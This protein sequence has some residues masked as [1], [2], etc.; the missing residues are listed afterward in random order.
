[1]ANPSTS[2]EILEWF[3]A[4]KVL[5]SA[6]IKD[7]F[8]FLYVLR[9]KQI[10]SEEEFKNWKDKVHSNPNDIRKVVYEVLENI[11]TNVSAVMEV[12]S[13][14]NLKNYQDLQSL[15]SS[16]QNV[17]QSAGNSSATEPGSSNLLQTNKDNSESSIRKQGKGIQNK[18]R[19]K[20]LG[21]LIVLCGKLKGVLYKRKLAAGVTQKCI[22]GLNGVWYTPREFEIAGGCVNAK[23]WRRSIR[24]RGVTLETLIKRGDLPEPARKSLKKVKPENDDTCEVCMEAG[25][26]MLCHS[27]CRSFHYSCHIP[28]E[29]P[30]RRRMWKC[31]LCKWKNSLFHKEDK[32]LKQRMAAKQTLACEFLLLKVWCEPESVVFA[33]QPITTQSYDNCLSRPMWLKQIN[34]KLREKQYETVGDFI[35]DMRLV[36]CNDQM[37]N[38]GQKTAE[39]GRKL[40]SEF[41]N[42]FREVFSICK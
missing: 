28:Q 6:A 15:H 18:E 3:R 38:Q 5:I 22:R 36:F 7:L 12:F 25:S 21:P 40:Q 14:E 35:G 11:K 4:N 31:T 32:V 26:E 33:Y 19:K 42:N 8:P 10:I 20:I 37:F 34:E 23:S 17:L 27:C 29:P 16:L 2:N 30:G 24:C 41:E 39:D 13:K 1:M 9:D